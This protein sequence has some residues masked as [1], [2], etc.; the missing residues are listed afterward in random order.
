MKTLLPQAEREEQGP[1]RT[2]VDP[3]LVARYVDLGKIGGGA[4]GEVRRVRDRDLNR[5]VAMKIIR[6]SLMTGPTALVR[7]IEEAQ[8]TAQ[9]QHPGIVPI[10]ELGRLPDGRLYYT[11]KE[12]HGQT[13]ASVI[14]EVHRVRGDI[15]PS[16]WTFRRL[17][18]VF[19]KVC[20]AMAY[21]HERG[22]IHRDL[23]PANVMLGD[24]GEVLVV[25]WGL[26][27]ILSSPDTTHKRVVTDRQCSDSVET[28]TGTV[29]GSPAYMSP[30]QAR[31]DISRIDRR[32]DVYALGA[33]LFEILYGVVPFRGTSGEV[34]AKVG[35]GSPP[36]IPQCSE[37]GVR[38]PQSLSRI[39]RTAMERDP[40]SRF[41]GASKM[42]AEVETWLNGERQR[43]RA[44]NMLKRAQTRP[45]Q[46]PHLWLEAMLIRKNA[47]AL[48]GDQ[49]LSTRDLEER[50]RA[51]D[52]QARDIERR[53]ERAELED[54][55]E[56]YAALTIDPALYEAHALLVERY[57]RD[58]SAAESRRD[59]RATARAGALVRQHLDQLPE[60][61][62][63]RT[64]TLTYLQGDGALTLWTD[65]PGAR[66]TIAQ[67]LFQ[68][69]RPQTQGIRSLGPTPLRAVSLPMGSYL[70]EIIHPNKESPPVRYPVRIRRQQHWDGIPPGGEEPHPIW[71]P[72]PNALDKHDC[73]V[74]A[75]WTH[76]GEAPET[77]SSLPSRALWL[78]GFV[79]R[80]F[81]V[82]NEEYLRF[83]RA[84]IDRGKT[85]DARYHAPW[86]PP[87]SDGGPGRMVYSLVKDRLELGRDL[88]GLLWLPQWPVR[89]VDLFGAMAYADWLAKESG[90]PWRLPTEFE[91]EKAARGV[92]ERSFPWGNRLEPR[93]FLHRD[94][95][96]QDPGPRHLD[97][98]PNDKS[99]YSVR[100]LAG[101]IADWTLSEFN[102]DWKRV[103]KG[104]APKPLMVDTNDTGPG[105]ARVI[106]GGSF[107]DEANQAGVA[108]RHR[109]PPFRR[110]LNVGS[111]VARP[112]S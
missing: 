92:D 49:S 48:R 59:D 46:A 93:W 110:G 1:T 99:P 3:E 75:G 80:R 25:D 55:R 43:T 62:P 22:V 6:P 100:G 96:Y 28:H 63:D 77:H 27:K 31:G 19:F 72:P 69:E 37:S 30:E 82:S 90:K 95:T 87:P 86:Q 42:A 112:I 17:M 4:M 44:L 33:I 18:D 109:S 89:L 23:K 10:H 91:W 11:M 36:C 39:C 26:V 76:L 21:A 32:S 54:K 24:H 2:A 15:P 105:L 73:Y 16:G 7:F 85:R 13:L 47:Q 83:L 52:S 103:G 108:T 98:F 106:R 45:L 60:R 68:S 29:A 84:L 51:L 53:A 50:V 66:V 74:P 79:I 9:L 102:L 94:S 107:R 78:P 71:L 8:A 111:R 41:Q 65:P 34:L 35:S 40:E 58:H 20:E 104:V 12:V 14:A 70:C 64:R 67:Y 81:P 101:N 88:D 56:I 5:T 57:L 61:H 97:S 38:V